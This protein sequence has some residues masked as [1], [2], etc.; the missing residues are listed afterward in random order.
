[1]NRLD[2]FDAD[3]ASLASLLAIDDPVLIDGHAEL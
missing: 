1:V 2:D 3:L